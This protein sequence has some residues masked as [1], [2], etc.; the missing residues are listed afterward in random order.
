MKARLPTGRE[1]TASQPVKCS[2][3]EI[4]SPCK[5]RGEWDAA[6]PP[7]GHESC[8]PLPACLQGLA[9]FL[10]RRCTIAYLGRTQRC[11][12]PRPLRTSRDVREQLTGVDPSWEACLEARLGCEAKQVR[13][14]APLRRSSQANRCGGRGGFGPGSRGNVSPAGGRVRERQDQQQPSVPTPNETTPASTSIT[15]MPQERCP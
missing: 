11:G 7:P 9:F 1:S 8:S 5:L 10:R 6:L 12:S 3:L 15:C 2:S 14:V 4:S 13:A